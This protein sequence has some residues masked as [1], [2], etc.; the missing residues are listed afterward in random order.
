MITSVDQQS[1]ICLVTVFRTSF[2]GGFSS[3]D[4]AKEVK[5]AFLSEEAKVMPM[6]NL[7]SEH[8]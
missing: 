3:A 5:I 8:F 2:A 6:K 4:A 1:C 7:T